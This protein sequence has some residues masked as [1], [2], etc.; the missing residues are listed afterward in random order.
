MSGRKPMSSMRSASSSTR[1]STRRQVDV[2]LA[3]MVEQAAGR[4]DEDVDAAP[5]L[6]D[7]R[8]E[9]D[10]AEHRHRARS[11]Q[12]LAVGADRRLDLRGELARR[13]EDQ[14]AHRLARPLRRRAARARARGAAASAARSRRSCR[15]RSARR[16]AGR[17]RR[18]PRES[19]GVG[20]GWAR[21]SPGRRPRATSASD[22]PS[23]ENDMVM[24]SKNV[25]GQSP[26]RGGQ[27]EPNGGCCGG[28]KRLRQGDWNKCRSAHLITLPGS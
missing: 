8:A 11:L 18:A 17:R 15:C 22:S 23:V 12:V 14:R 16:R 2:A 25:L 19:P 5:Q 9:A 27:S 21:C 20:S 26:V 28:R 24:L 7:L 13:R 3:V 10:A 4:R 1:I 6:R